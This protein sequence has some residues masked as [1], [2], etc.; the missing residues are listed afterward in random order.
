M[1]SQASS[2]SPVSGNRNP[3]WWI[4]TSLATL[5]ALVALPATA[6]EC[7]DWYQDADGDGYGDEDITQSVCDGSDPGSGWRLIAGDCDD[8]APLVNPAAPE[9]C[10]DLDNDCDG[11]VNSGLPLYAYY[12]DRDGD[13]FGDPAA[14]LPACGLICLEVCVA[15]VCSDVC[16][17]D[18]GD[19]CD[20]ADPLV[21]PDAEELCNHVDDDCDGAEDEGLR[22]TLFLDRDD[23]LYG[24]D[25]TGTDGYCGADDELLDLSLGPGLTVAPT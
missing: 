5:L 10:D 11:T 12:E 20:D 22:P 19:D 8:S 13:G 6:Q 4:G 21:H 3:C 7:V 16:V 17:A 9:I 1:A 14:L 24:D 2:F 15:D 23:D 25:S 18:N